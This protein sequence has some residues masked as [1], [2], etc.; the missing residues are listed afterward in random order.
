MLI[1][2]IIFCNFI[3]G[4]ILYRRDKMK[5]IDFKKILNSKAFNRIVI[6]I[7][8]VTLVYSLYNIGITIYHSVRNKSM[9]DD[10]HAIL[11]NDQYEGKSFHDPS[12]N[13]LLS[14]IVLNESPDNDEGQDEKREVL[15][16]YKGLLMINEDIIGWIKVPGTDIDYPIVQG[17]DNDYYLN[18]THTGEKNRHGAIFMDYRNSKY[19]DD[20]NTVIYGHNMRL[21][22]NMFRPLTKFAQDQEFFNKNRIIQI[23]S[24]YGEQ[25]WEIF[26]VYVTEINFNYIKRSFASPEEFKTF[27]AAIRERSAF[28]TD[29]I[30][31]EHDNIVTLSTCT[32]E[33]KDARFVVHAKKIKE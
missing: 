18:T 13:T 6:V 21:A 20:M 23:D 33:Y 8:V 31:T 15:E 28:P 29:T 25:K 7:C 27:I 4:N 3:E 16:K 2:G 24:I 17:K 14:K 5:K 32:Y 22:P 1:Y 30:V 26:S 11:N 9:I 12:F 19:F 10:I